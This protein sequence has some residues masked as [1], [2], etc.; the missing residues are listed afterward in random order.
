MQ[1]KQ[2][3]T[4]HGNAPKGSGSNLRSKTHIH[5]I[6]I[7]A[8]KPLQIIKV[9]TPTGWGKQK[10]TLIATY[11]ALMRPALEYAS[12]IWS[13][14]ACSSSINKLHYHLTTYPSSLQSTYGM[15]IDCN[16]TY[17]HL[18]TTRKPTGHNLP[19]TQSPL[20]LRPQYPPTRLFNTLLSV[21]LSIAVL[22]NEVCIAWSNYFLVLASN[23][24]AVWW[25]LVKNVS[26]DGPSW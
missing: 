1:N 11:K 16:K 8:H 3:C 23:R 19:K 22:I 4:T 6:S 14:L 26:V 15:T 12:S 5:H 7:H 20:S 10:E 13:P 2:H 17:A 24:N 21:M 18:Q 9:L 25:C